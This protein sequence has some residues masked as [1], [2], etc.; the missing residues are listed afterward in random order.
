[1]RYVFDL[2]GTLCTQTA[3][4]YNFAMPIPER[5]AMVNRLYDEGHDIIIF[6]ARGMSEKDETSATLRYWD[7]TETQLKHWGVKYHELIFG[8]PS[9]DIYVDDK[10]MNASEFFRT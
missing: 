6:T 1:M 8:K 5:I 3:S 10:G 9:G 4:L 2:D 7:L